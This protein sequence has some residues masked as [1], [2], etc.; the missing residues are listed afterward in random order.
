[1]IKDD[2]CW[3]LFRVPPQNVKTKR[4]ERIQS[5]DQLRIYTEN[6]KLI[7]LG[8]NLRTMIGGSDDKAI[9]LCPTDSDQMRFSPQET[10]EVGRAHHL[11]HHRVRSRPATTSGGRHS[12]FPAPSPFVQKTIQSEQLHIQ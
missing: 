6:P 2:C 12:T 10:T 9:R 5:R 3:F 7:D 8:K 11:A 1:M 4:K